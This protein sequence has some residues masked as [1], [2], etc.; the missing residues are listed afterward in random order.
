[1]DLFPGWDLRIRTQSKKEL[2]LCIDAYLFGELTQLE[3]AAVEI[4]GQVLTDIIKNVLM[5]WAMAMFSRLEQDA[6]DN[7][8][9]RENDQ[10]RLISKRYHS[11]QL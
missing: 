3:A 7:K 4:F 5:N 8:R 6:P 10:V 1:V 9:F 2:E 11:F